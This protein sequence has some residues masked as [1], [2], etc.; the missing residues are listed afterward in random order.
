[1]KLHCTCGEGE[2]K[3]PSRWERFQR[4]C[5]RKMYFKKKHKYCVEKGGKKCEKDIWRTKDC[6]PSLC[7]T[8]NENSE[9]ERDGDGER[10]IMH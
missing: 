10:L 4:F 7:F 6:Y 9:S 1:M 5:C 2:K 8:V 3:P